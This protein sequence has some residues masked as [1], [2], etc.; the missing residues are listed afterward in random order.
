MNNKDA[1][2]VSIGLNDG[3]NKFPGAR[4]VLIVGTTSLI[5]S[6][7]ICLEPHLRT[8]RVDF[9]QATGSHGKSVNKLSTNVSQTSF[10]YKPF[11]HYQTT[12]VTHNICIGC[13]IMYSCRK[14]YGIVGWY[15]T[16]Q[17]IVI[18][19]QKP[20]SLSTVHSGFWNKQ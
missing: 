14:C 17:N 13:F 1:L 2:S 9:H 19:N 5:S 15:K 16:W 18:I 20:L 10:W 6:S 4:R 12:K 11:T 7:N 8:D 3:T